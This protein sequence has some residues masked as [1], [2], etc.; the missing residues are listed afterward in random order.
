M[1]GRLSS[2]VDGK[3]QSFPVH[4]WREEFFLAKEAGLDLIEWIYEKETQTVNPIIN[5]DGIKEIKKHMRETSVDVRS[6]CA[7]YFM[8]E[9]LINSQSKPILNNINHLK[10]LIKR[11]DKLS[12]DY[13]ILPFVD[14]SRLK[15]QEDINIL[16]QILEEIIPLTEEFG[17][18]LHLETDLPP[19]ILNGIFGKINHPLIRLNYDIGNSASLGYDP[20]LELNLLSQWVSSIH[21]KDRLLHGTTVP[22]G[23]GSAD[24]PLCFELLKKIHYSRNF[25][26]QAARQ[27]E[28][29]EIELAMKNK[30]YVI[31]LLSG[32]GFKI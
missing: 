12:I 2:P 16:I 24:L 32:A 31:H 28:M 30:E 15:S 13:I 5:Y 19:D 23:S 9:F 26:L 29:S 8:S 18:E 27:N 22:L 21:V 11:G 6:I 4:S 1:Q 17:I 10:W 3:I 25:I 7:D 14:S 20:N